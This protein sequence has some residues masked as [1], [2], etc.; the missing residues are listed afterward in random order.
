MPKRPPTP[1][2]EPRDGRGDLPPHGALSTDDEGDRVQ[3]HICGRMYRSL[4]LH[5]RRRHGVSPDAYR[6][7]YGL[8]RTA[9]L[10]APALRAALADIHRDH[11]AA[12]RPD[13]T[14]VMELAAQRRAVGTD[15]PRRLQGRIR[16][17]EAKR[18][19]YAQRPRPRRPAPEAMPLDERMARAHAGR[20]AAIATP[21]GRAAWRAAIRESR[22]TLTPAQEQEIRALCGQVPQQEAMRRY[23]VGRLTV[24]RLWRAAAP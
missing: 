15:Q 12:V 16:S 2:L 4:G 24:V 7:M 1:H 8:N 23:R 14:P 11:L 21:E 19:L 18:D 6:E 13:V 20:A 5:A 9:S 10:A 22:R 3:C 17:S